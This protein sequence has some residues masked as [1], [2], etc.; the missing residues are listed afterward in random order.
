[1]LKRYQ[2]ILMGYHIFQD[3]VACIFYN[4]EIDYRE[5]VSGIKINIKSSSWYQ[6]TYRGGMFDLG[7]HYG[8]IT[9]QSFIT[10]RL[11]GPWAARN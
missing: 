5:F 1:M 11:D 3:W 6:K 8:F 9:H 7:S 2:I 4:I 10:D